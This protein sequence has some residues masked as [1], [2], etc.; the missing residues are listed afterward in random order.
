MV[1]QFV[2][3]DDIYRRTTDLHKNLNPGQLL[4]IEK[5]WD[6]GFILISNDATHLFYVNYIDWQKIT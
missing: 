2:E 5:S 1:E 3:I 4:Q 6:L